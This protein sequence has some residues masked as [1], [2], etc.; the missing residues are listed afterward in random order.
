MGYINKLN[1][2]EDFNS[3]KYLKCMIK[4]MRDWLDVKERAGV[5]EISHYKGKIEKEIVN[6]EIESL[7]LFSNSIVKKMREL[8]MDRE[9]ILEFK[10]T[11]HT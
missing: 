8:G 6:T 7:S 5:N 4:G 11:F 1:A 3:L 2:R 9:L 10:L